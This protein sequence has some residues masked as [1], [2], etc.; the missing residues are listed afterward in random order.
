MEVG[1]E[2]NAYH[3]DDM[4]DVYISQKHR[5]DITMPDT[6]RKYDIVNKERLMFLKT[7]SGSYPESRNTFTMNALKT[8]VERIETTDGDNV[9]IPVEYENMV[10]RLHSAD[11]ASLQKISAPVRKYL[12]PDDMEDLD[13][14]NSAP[15]IIF[16]I[17]K[18]HG[19][20]PLY[21]EQ[22]L[23]DYKEKLTS[24]WPDWKVAKEM[25]SV[26]FFGHLDRHDEQ[27]EWVNCLSNDLDN[28]F[29]R[30]KALPEYADILAKATTAD[31]DKRESKKGAKKSKHHVENVRGH[32]FSYLYFM[33]ESMVLDEIDKCGVRE[34][35]WDNKVSL[36]FDGLMYLKKPNKRAN[37][38][39]LEKAV[40]DSLG[41]R[42]KI[43]RKPM[44]RLFN[45]SIHD[46]PDE[47]VVTGGDNEAADIVVLKLK[48]RIVNCQ[49]KLFMDIDGVWQSTKVREKIADAIGS[50]NIKSL[51]VSKSTGEETEVNYSCNYKDAINICRFAMMRFPEDNT[52]QRVLSL[53]SECK[54]AFRN[55][56]W[57]FTEDKH[58]GIH[59]RFVEGG[60]FRTG[61]RIERQLL[62][63]IEDDIKFV[64]DKLITPVF[65]TN[66]PGTKELFLHSVARALA[67]HTDKVTNILFGQRDSSKSVVMQFI[68]NAIE[69][70][71]CKIPSAVFVIGK[72]AGDP[73]R[74]SSWIL[75]AEFA[76]VAIVSEN[77][78]SK[79]GET[80]FSGDMLKKFQS[81][82]E[83][84]AARRNYEDQRDVYSCVTGF[85]LTNDIPRFDPG[86]AIEKCHIFHFR[87]KFV[88]AEE[89]AAHPFQTVYKLADPAVESWIRNPAYQNAL[90]HI[91]FRHYSPEKVVPNGTMKEDI[92]MMMQDCGPEMYDRLFDITLREDDYVSQ[93]QVKEHIRKNLGQTFGHS[94]IKSDLENIIRE[95]C[96]QENIPFF[97]VDG[98]PGTA[99]S[100]K[101]VYK[102]LKLKMVQE[103]MYAGGGGDEGAF[104]AGFMP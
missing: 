40:K 9:L 2:S 80:V 68:S 78:Q 60:R 61:V 54:L 47:L 45:P 90:L 12:V 32:F 57:E 20:R 21:L 44:E 42:I 92:D 8:M 79:E 94:K 48:D 6:V 67:G 28:L 86:D 88:S 95:R 24:I 18:K 74:Q 82:K 10:W 51:V 81:C 103:D 5:S 56:Y 27:P 87:N 53:E 13:I 89:M 16:G 63:P 29:I 98:R 91:I 104:A 30:L 64:M 1:V 100:R 59:G 26:L 41:I 25:K 52:F 77:A 70:Y 71:C 96:A 43:E 85:M 84:M 4:H 62:P 3:L 35:Y 23:D 14:V 34:G 76:R 101:R 39:T 38:S 69:G 66:E 31:A 55:G 33:Y 65:D 49:G 7:F 83:G 97:K 17:A 11:S 50:M 72:M 102:G 22:F 58:D 37:L 75:D 73:Y 19:L 93:A 15:T 99:G 46:L 36:I